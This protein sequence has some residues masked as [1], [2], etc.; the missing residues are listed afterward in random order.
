MTAT[1]SSSK[2]ASAEQKTGRKPAYVSK[3]LGIDSHLSTRNGST[4]HVYCIASARPAGRK[5]ADD[6]ARC[7]NGMAADGYEVL[8]IAPVISGHTAEASAEAADSV[9]GRTYVAKDG[10]PYVDTGVGY[11]VTDGVII[12]GRLRV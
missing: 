7:C 4:D 6:I 2:S 5:L 3:Y 1:S 12:T 9:P 10:K 11:S 8:S